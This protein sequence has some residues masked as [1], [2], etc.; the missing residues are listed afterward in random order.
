LKP[1]LSLRHLADLVR[2]HVERLSIPAEIAVVTVRAVLVAPLEFHQGEMFDDG[3]AS[4][5]RAT[6]ALVERL[7]SRLGEDSVLRP[8]LVPDPQPE[9]ACT[10][11]P[12]EKGVRTLFRLDVDCPSERN[13]RKRV[14]TPF[15]PLRPPSLKTEPVAVEV[16]SVVPEGPPIRF[17]WGGRWHAVGQCWGPERIE[18]GW[19]RGDDVRRDYYLIETKD[20]ECYWLFRTQP[21][22]RW[23]FQAMY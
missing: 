22:E 18:T 11:E 6:A 23:F 2:L 17:R 5:E 20:G 3:G 1:S 10:F 9:F 16:M 15:S 21:D 4:T 13:G 12:W 19:W 7:S 8:R 14:L